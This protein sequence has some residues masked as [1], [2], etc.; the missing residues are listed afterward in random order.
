MATIK[1]QVP[2]IH[3]NGSAQSIL[4]EDLRNAAEAVSFAIDRL[5]KTAPHM[6]DFYVRQDLS[7]APPEPCGERD[8]RE[9][10]EQHRN[11]LRTLNRVYAEL[12]AVFEA[13]D[14]KEA[15]TTLEIGE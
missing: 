11:R 15:E 3:L 6:R 9:A 2:T 12:F 4:M 7:K 10:A 8:F 14:K 5:A 13:I 1:L